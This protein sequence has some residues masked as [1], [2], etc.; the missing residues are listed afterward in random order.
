MTL[1]EEALTLISDN[2]A[3]IGEKMSNFAPLIQ[4]MLD[5]GNHITYRNEYGYMLGSRI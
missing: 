4:R 1:D 3:A 2:S 5:N